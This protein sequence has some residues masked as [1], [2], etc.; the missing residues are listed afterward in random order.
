MTRKSPNPEGRPPRYGKTKARVN[1]TLTEESI[2]GLDRLAEDLGL[3]RSELVERIGRGLIPLHPN[4]LSVEEKE[5]LGKHF[6]S[7]FPYIETNLS[8]VVSI[9][10]TKLR[11]I[12]HRATA[13]LHA[14]SS[15]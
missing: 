2:T 4:T 11:A 7:L 3:S 1:L 13:S 6:Q 10:S 8:V 15:Y 9:G 14:A 5:S 12:R